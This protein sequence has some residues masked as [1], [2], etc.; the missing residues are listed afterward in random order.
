ML[1]AISRRF[2]LGSLIAAV[3][4]TLVACGGG[5]P[6]VQTVVVEKVVEK[7]VLVVQTAA[8]KVVEKTVLVVETAA[9]KIVEK[10]V[11][12]VQTATPVGYQSASV[13]TKPSIVR[14][15]RQITWALDSN[16]PTLDVHK[17]TANPRIGAL[18]A[19][20]TLFSFDADLIPQPVLVRDWS[21]SKDGLTW[22]FKL[23]EGITFNGPVEGRPFTSEHAMRSWKRW[24][25][26]DN[27][28]I[29][30]NKFIASIET[31]D[32]LT[33]VVTL[34]EPSGLLLDGFARIGGHEPV[35]MPPEMYEVSP[36]KGPGPGEMETFGGT[37]PYKLVSW[38]G[39]RIR[40][41]KW[42]GYKSPAGPVSFYA[43]AKHAH[44]RALEAVV[45]PESGARIAALSTG[46]VDW[47][48]VIPGEQRSRVQAMKD[49]SVWVNET[50]AVRIG[51]W[52]DHVEG[53]MSHAA[54][55]K[56][57]MMAY[58]KENALL[59]AA[60]SRDLYRTCGSLMICKTRWGG[61]RTPGDE[62]YYD[63]PNVKAAKQL[64]ADAGVSGA[65]VILLAVEATANVAQVTQS[66]LTDLGFVV[67]LQVSDAATYSKRRSDPKTMD[68]FHTGGPVSWGGISPLL[69]SSISKKTFWNNYQDPTGRFTAMLDEFAKAPRER[70]DELIKEMQMLFYQD[71]QYIPIGET[72]PLIAQKSKLRGVEINMG[73]P[74]SMVNAWLDD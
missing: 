61:L 13:P 51:V 27:F 22:T 69:N 32:P 20:E 30:L 38:K 41:E 7:T 45:I 55:R 47:I 59:V 10:T 52:P 42:G 29:I 46:Q 56:A 64:V 44:A 65:T 19:Q 21:T 17:T 2:W 25:E 18:H 50:G 31:P 40:F 12:V 6:E 23:R 8:P 15:S 70:Q 53:P 63:P 54:V 49:V 71:L 28:G 34:K 60:G 58:P 24:I 9:P 37:G 33:L 67:D 3:A 73:G 11:L 1:K 5:Q 62:I 43:G 36:E 74:P 16:I 72:L 68:L 26:R 35:M 14:S 39:D 57:L 4:L 66:V 48:G